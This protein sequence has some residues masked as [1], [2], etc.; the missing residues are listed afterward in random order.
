MVLPVFH[1]PPPISSLCLSGDSS[2]SPG[3][4]PNLFLPSHWPF[5]SSLKPITVTH[6]LDI[7]LPYNMILGLW[8]FFPILFYWRCGSTAAGSNIGGCLGHQG[9]DITC[10]LIHGLVLN[11]MMFWGGVWTRGRSECVLGSE[12]FD[13]S[14][15][16]F[17]LT[18]QPL[19][20]VYSSFRV[21]SQVHSLTPFHRPKANGSRPIM[22]YSSEPNEPFLLEVT[23]SR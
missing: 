11:L 19:L 6:L 20:C 3:F 9:L 8:S 14:S 13:I 15:F 17:K 7:Q 12:Y 18:L 2:L 1:L 10:K 16:I 4:L 22:E 21:L 23:Y 5:I